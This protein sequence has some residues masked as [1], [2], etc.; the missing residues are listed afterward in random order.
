MACFQDPYSF[1]EELEIIRTVEWLK[2]VKYQQML[3]FF[4]HIER[5]SE[6]LSDWGRRYG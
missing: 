3:C 1:P 5:L 4:A 2:G 6:F